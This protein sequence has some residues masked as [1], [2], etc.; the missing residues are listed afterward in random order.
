MEGRRRQDRH[1]PHGGDHGPPSRPDRRARGKRARACRR[2][3]HARIHATGGAG[4]L[5]GARAVAGAQG[6]DRLLHGRA[7]C[8]PSARSTRSSP[9]SR[10]GAVLEAPQH[11]P[12]TAAEPHLA[13]GRALAHHLQPGR[14]FHGRLSTSNPNLQ[15]IPIRTE[16]GR[17]I[18]SAF[19][20]EAGHRLLSA[21]YSWSN[22]ASW[23]VSG[24]P[25]P[26]GVRAGRGHPR[27]TQPEV[28][29]KEGRRSRRTSATS[30]RW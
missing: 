26:R 29:G 13:G 18:R 24:E 14:R 6:Q 16:L 11:V 8:G 12:G 3:V 5:R 2:R 9:S 28:I 30:P 7:F 19:V 21:D 20:A 17:E 15:A 1:V 22:C 10:N 4:S 27:R 23:R 25:A